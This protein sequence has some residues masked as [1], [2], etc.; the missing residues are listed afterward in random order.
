MRVKTNTSNWTEISY[1]D[2]FTKLT[3]FLRKQHEKPVRRS[4][5]GCGRPTSGIDFFVSKDSAYHSAVFF[6][7]P[8]CVQTPRTLR[9]VENMF[10]KDDDQDVSEDE[11]DEFQ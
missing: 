3:T 5:L 1:K 6:L 4:C 11:E 2:F 8:E 9:E 7:C 10:K